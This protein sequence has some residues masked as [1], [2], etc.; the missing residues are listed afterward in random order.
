MI[1]G[2]VN[3]IIPFSSVDGPGNRTAIFLQECNFNC[4]YCHNPETINKC[5]NCG[6]CVDVCPT[7]ALTIE[8]G[9]VLW[10]KQKCCECDACT[11]KCSI[12]SSPKILKMTPDD[13]INEIMNYRP[14]I[15]GITLSGGG[16]CTLQE[17]FLIELFKKAKNIG[18]TCL[19]DS[20]GSN[21]FE[22]MTELTELCDGVMLDVKSWSKSIHDKYIEFNN[23]NVIKNLEYLANM[24]KL[25][26]VRTVIVPNLFDNEETVRKVSEFIG[27]VN[28]KIRYKLIKFRAL[29]VRDEIKGHQ[30]PSDN[31][32]EMLKVIA[33]E[34]G[35]N[36]IIIV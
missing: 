34:N 26:E 14:F 4:I 23:Y 33:E 30:S 19:V 11:K 35:C 20:N 13:V 3:K 29:G 16:E 27:K 2:Y 21:D 5:I 15:K 6:T 32:M 1:Y 12:S 28:G 22:K 31:Y 9:K 18:L 10:N 36:N 24:G 17:E 7:S 25:Y 8:D